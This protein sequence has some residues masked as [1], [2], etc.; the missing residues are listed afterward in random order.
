[1]TLNPDHPLTAIIIRLSS[2][3]NLNVP[4]NDLAEDI[5]RAVE[6]YRQL[7]R[8][9]DAQNKMYEYALL[10]IIG[11]FIQVLTEVETSEEKLNAVLQTVLS[12][13]LDGESN[14]VA[15]KKN[16]ISEENRE[17]LKRWLEEHKDNPYPTLEDKDQLVTETG[18]CTRQVEDWFINARR[19]YLPKPASP[20]SP[21]STNNNK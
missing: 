5:L 1:M 3:I 15:K 21:P 10:Q 14:K 11:F 19:R 16:M 20:A 13:N 17:K 2:A 4:I 6:Q 18:L 12:E 8:E 9:D 7:R